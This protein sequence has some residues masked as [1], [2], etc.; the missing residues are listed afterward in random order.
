MEKIGIR[1]EGEAEGET[2]RRTNERT[3]GPKTKQM[4][5]GRVA[6]KQAPL[7]FVRSPPVSDL[8]RVNV[9]H[10]LKLKPAGHAAQWP[11]KHRCNSI[12]RISC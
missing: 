8:G 12:I 5:V 7:K 6:Q 4:D 10:K 2:D 1:R 11:S 9:M 3:N